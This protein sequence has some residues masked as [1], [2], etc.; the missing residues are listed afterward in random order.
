MNPLIPLPCSSPST[1]KD[2]NPEPRGLSASPSAG[3]SAALHVTRQGQPQDHHTLGMR[4]PMAAPC[5]GSRRID[6]LKL[7]THTLQ[8]LCATS[9]SRPG[10]LKDHS[11]ESSPGTAWSWAF[12]SSW[13]SQASESYP[14]PSEG[15]AF[16][17]PPLCPSA[18]HSSSLNDLQIPPR[19]PL[20]SLL[21]FP[22]SSS[23]LPALLAL[24][25]VS[26]L[27]SFFSQDQE[28]QAVTRPQT[29]GSVCLILRAWHM[30]GT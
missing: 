22:A 5:L 2:V 28:P 18:H 20:S 6:P 17:P 16:L 29:S 23:L 26:C 11:Q 14:R 8:E 3:K 25:I 24:C 13:P 7:L 27:K 10:S 4:D 12:C 1:C 19:S 30:P 15:C 21:S 9:R